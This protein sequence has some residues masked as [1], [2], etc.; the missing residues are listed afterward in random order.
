MSDT[1]HIVDAPR[2][3]WRTEDGQLIDGDQLRNDDFEIDLTAGSAKIVR[4]QRPN[5]HPWADKWPTWIGL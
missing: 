4:K 5:S 1:M 3:A 2:P